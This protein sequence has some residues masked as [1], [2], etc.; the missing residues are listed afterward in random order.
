LVVFLVFLNLSGSFAEVNAANVS[1]AQR[2]VVDA[3]A[4]PQIKGLTCAKSEAFQGIEV[5]SWILAGGMILIIGVP[6]FLPTSLVGRRSWGFYTFGS[7]SAAL[8]FVAAITV[9]EAK[10]ANPSYRKDFATASIIFQFL[11]PSV[12]LV[13]AVYK[14][15]HKLA[16]S[17]S[18]F[19]VNKREDVYR[20]HDAS[21]QQHGAGFS[22]I[23]GMYDVPSDLSTI[24]MTRHDV[25]TARESSR[26]RGVNVLPR[27][28]DPRIPLTT[29][30]P[31]TLRRQPIGG[32]P[33][34]FTPVRGGVNNVSFTLAPGALGS[35]SSIQPIQE[36]RV[37]PGHPTFGVAIQKGKGKGKGK[38]VES[39][40]WQY[41][42][43]KYSI[44][45][46]FGL[47]GLI[48]AI[49]T[50]VHWTNCGVMSGEGTASDDTQNLPQKSLETTSTH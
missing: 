12:L 9:T 11:A 16:D 40:S 1:G 13:L 10:G 38:E 43:K 5:A 37:S 26:A 25:Q 31:T 36:D 46:V 21:L 30:T 24:S 7:I 17:A 42:L 33:S 47:A 14:L 48:L 6:L 29:H 18:N 45:L 15:R 34:R 2:E 27:R 44:E 41:L 23:P 8:F 28:R 19:S 32:A 20:V 22:E 50:T 4:F 3:Q 49:Y 39:S 35:R